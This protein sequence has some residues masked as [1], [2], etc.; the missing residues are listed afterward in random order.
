MPEVSPLPLAHPKNISKREAKREKTRALAEANVA[1]AKA[2]QDLTAF[3]E[4]ARRADVP[5]GWLRD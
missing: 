3:R 5:P 2:R 1:L 4:Q